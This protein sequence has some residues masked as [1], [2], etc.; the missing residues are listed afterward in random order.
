MPRA[1]KTTMIPVVPTASPVAPNVPVV[2]TASPVAPNHRLLALA[3]GLAFVLLCSG[4]FD[5]EAPQHYRC[6]VAEPA[7]PP[8]LV[9]SSGLC[10]QRGAADAASDLTTD[11]KA[12]AG[13]DAA[14]DMTADGAPDA[15]IDT[16]TSDS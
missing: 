15:L 5:V 3:S 14:P 9:C 1:M 2:P 8:G 16:S 6:S 11:T 13:I 10:V 7:C 4:C 12:D